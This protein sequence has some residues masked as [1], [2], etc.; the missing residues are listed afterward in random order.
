MKIP[1]SFWASSDTGD[2]YSNPYNSP[3]ENF[4][5]L[6]VMSD[7]VP[8]T[9][10]YLNSLA[11]N[12][13]VAGSTREFSDQYTAQQSDDLLEA[14]ANTNQYTINTCEIDITADRNFYFEEDWG[15]FNIHGTPNLIFWLGVDFPIN[16]TG[17][18]PNVASLPASGNLYDIVFV[19]DITEY[20]FFLN[21]VLFSIFL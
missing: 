1:F 13:D 16:F 11:Y 20:L 18:V 12:E 9:A 14:A 2:E 7:A 17:T 8:R 19:L 6:S 3:I 10:E 5:Y 21:F 15:N 4:R